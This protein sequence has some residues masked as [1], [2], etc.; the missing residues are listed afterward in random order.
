MDI[1]SPI[2][3]FIA[4]VRSIGVVKADDELFT[5]YSPD[6]DSRIDRVQ[7]RQQELT[8][9]ARQFSDGRREEW[10]KLQ[11]A[12]L[13]Q[14]RIQQDAQFHLHEAVLAQHT[15][16]ADPMEEVQA[17]LIPLALVR[18]SLLQQ[19]QTVA[20]FDRETKDMMDD[21]ALKTEHAKRDLERL[22]DLKKRL[23]I[24]APFP[25]EFTPRFTKG[26]FCG[27]NECLGVLIP[28]G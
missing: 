8:I 16:G 17:S 19:E 18:S 12:L 2:D 25:G 23:I 13:E 3:C 21:L 6:L 14:A 27:I 24:K 22:N 4:Q 9:S 20:E 1:N 28:W 10:K 7:V 11:V 5:L 26:S 15:T